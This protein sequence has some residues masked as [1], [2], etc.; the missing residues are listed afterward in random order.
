[1]TRSLLEGTTTLVV[2]GEAITPGSVRS[3]SCGFGATAGSLLDSAGS[4]LF[5]D[6]GTGVC[7]EGGGVGCVDDVWDGGRD[8]GF[9]AVGCDD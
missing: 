7:C 1:M 6:D 5:R 2:I 3:I 8:D 4:L 9:S